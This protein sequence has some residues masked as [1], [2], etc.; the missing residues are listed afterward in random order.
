MGFEPKLFAAR[1]KSWLLWGKGNFPFS[2]PLMEETLDHNPRLM[3]FLRAPFIPQSTQRHPENHGPSSKDEIVR[4]EEE[5]TLL[6]IDA[7]PLPAFN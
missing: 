6:A 3:D 2:I 1:G 7:L 4:K 5:K